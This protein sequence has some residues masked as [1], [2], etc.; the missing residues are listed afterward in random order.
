MPTQLENS[1]GPSTLYRLLIASMVQANFYSREFTAHIG[2]CR[3]YCNN[4]LKKINSFL[5]FWTHQKSTLYFSSH[6]NTLHW[7]YSM[8]SQ[9]IP[10]QK[11]PSWTKSYPSSKDPSLS[12]VRPTTSKNKP[13][14]NKPIQP[15]TSH[16]KRIAWCSPTAQ[17]SSSTNL[18]LVTQLW[19]QP[20]TAS[21]QRQNT[22]TWTHLTC[23]TMVSSKLLK[24]C[25]EQNKTKNK[26]K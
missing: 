20:M 8:N 26:K 5:S 24:Y 15:Q 16:K 11:N 13:K 6:Q 4:T 25:T 18:A 19:L 17:S 9:K 1:H 10:F 23:L 3:H 22:C 21:L 2:T 7:L 12:G 14:I